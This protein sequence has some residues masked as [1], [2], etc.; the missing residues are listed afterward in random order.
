MHSTVSAVQYCII[1]VSYSYY[2]ALSL[3]F[4]QNKRT[5]LHWASANC[6]EDCMKVLLE[7]G[8]DANA[9]DKVQ[10]YAVMC[11]AFYTLSYSCTVVST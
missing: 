8:A 9:L 10:L 5:P 7:H 1:P 2:L 11:S 4:E 3:Y 6:H